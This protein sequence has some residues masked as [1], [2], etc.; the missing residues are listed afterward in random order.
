[1]RVYSFTLAANA[2][3]QINAQG[4][5][6]RCLTAAATFDMVA[7][8]V[9]GTS[10]GDFN[11]FQAGLAVTCPGQFAVVDITNGTTGQTVAI[12]IHDGPVDDNRLVG[13]VNITGGL[14]SKALLP[15]VATVPATVSIGTVA[16]VIVAASTRRGT[17][18]IQNMHATND[19]YIG[20]TSAVTTA[21]GIWI[22][23]KG[24]MEVSA[25]TG[26]WGVASGASTDV[27]VM[28]A[29]FA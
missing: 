14:D 5:F 4:T 6:I 10:L 20:L 19:L 3:A 26:V 9:D 8:T 18:V 17:L 12:L 27:R 7:K 11:G 29:E 25:A 24:S 16:D 21:N 28:Q 1:M 13:I 2:T 22:G 15:G 23:P